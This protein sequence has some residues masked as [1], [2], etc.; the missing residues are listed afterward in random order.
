MKYKTSHALQFVCF[1]LV[2]MS[3]Q[4]WAQAN[5]S[6]SGTVSDKTGSVIPGAKVS[7]HSQG[8][9]IERTA[10]TD[11]S[12][13]YTVPLLPVA[14][15]KLEVSAAN[16]QTVQQHDIQ[17]Q[18]DEH[19]EVNFSLALASVSEKVEVEANTEEVAV[20]TTNP[21]LGQ[22]INEKQVAQLPLNGRNFVQL[23]TLTPGTTQETNP[24][25]FFNGGGSSEVSTRG[26]FSLSV[27]GSRASSTDWLFDDADNNELTAGG[28]AVIPSIDAIQEFKVLTFNYSAQYGTRAGPTVLI[29]S[30]SGSNGFHGTAFEFFRNTALDAKSYFAQTKEKFNLNQFGFSLGGPI[31]K[32]KTFFFIDY[33]ATRR[34]TGENFFGGF[35]PTAGMHT[36]DFSS[37]AAQLYN[38]YSTHLATVGGVQ[39]AVR[40][41]FMCDGAG[42]ALAV[43]SDGT[44]ASGTPCNI[45]PQALIDPVAQQMI[46]LF[47]LPNLSGNSGGNYISSPTKKLDEGSFD[48][49][50]DHN[51]T[52]S[53]RL[54]A[55]FSYDQATVFLPGGTPGFAEPDPFSSTQNITNHGRNAAISETHIFSNTSVNEAKFGYD[56]IFNHINSFGTGSCIGNTLGIPGA[57]LG[58]VSCGLTATSIGGGYWGLGDRGFAPFQGGTN[59]FDISD[60]FDMIRGKHNIRIGGEIRANQMNVLTN[61]F[62]DGFWVY[63]N[64][65]SSA[66]GT[67]PGT[68]INAAGFGGGDNMA[69]FMLGL[70]DLAL[71]DQTFK[72]ATTGRRWKLYRPYVQDDWQVNKD[73]TLNLG[74]AWAFVTPI[75]ESENRQANFDFATGTFLIP[76]VN[77]N[78]AV[79]IKMDKTAVE[80]RIG[81]AWK[82]FGSAKTAVRAGY[83]IF[84]DSS[85][86]QGGQ[87]LWENPPFFQESAFAAFF[88]DLCPTASG[89]CANSFTP[90]GKTMSQGFP[91]LS[92]PTDPAT[93]GGNLQ[94]QNLNFKI[95]R[96]QQYNVNVERELPG[97]VVLTVGYAGSRSSHVLIDGINLNVGSPAACGV[98]SGYTLGCGAGGAAFGAPYPQYGTIANNGDTG[99]AHYDS[100]QIKAETKNIKHGLYALIGYTHARALDT[101][102]A[103]GIGTS[104][105]STYYP[106]PGTSKND[107]GLSQISVNHSFTGSVIYD[108][109]FGRGRQFGAN[110]NRVEDAALGGWQLNVIERIMS[111]FPLFMTAS[112]NNSG[113]SFASNANRPNQLCTGQLSDWTVNKFFDTTCYV[114]PPQGQLGNSS[115]TPLFGP[116]FVNTDLSAVKFFHFTEQTSMEFRAE[117]FNVFN[118]A[119]FYVPVTDVDSANFGQIT[120]TVNNPRLIQFALKIHF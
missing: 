96:V 46:N 14:T 81:V 93:F 6:F 95:G 37:L 65:W 38:P 73:L 9:G 55:R 76:G 67:I 5:G 78:G 63:T 16:F 71:H 43:G 35:V 10:I 108:L 114:D 39:T 19:R 94:S 1:L 21:T 18:V 85:W 91:I 13:H 29:T 72:G 11:G 23:A 17:L 8:T 86:N 110:W 41:P 27:G 103:D 64:S 116:G 102:F 49:R 57:N 20:Q 117:F 54:F 115:R 120:E 105:G 74:L 52:N 51:L 24:H 113:V 80:P 60:S 53:D 59:V 101:G 111:G 31:R 15:Y 22:V 104:T 56:R 33:Q 44:Q 50:L 83:G 84:H 2:L 70:P 34:R 112:S 45:I 68:T 100:L 92:Q 90:T 30:K 7:I 87:G 36:G 98:V 25:S 118:H 61:A 97:A 99:K 89:A 12:G 69:D 79:G 42:N 32:D 107:W 58:G 3:A 106:L 75:T 119:Q 66:T 77:S 47:P 88:P 109:P 4:C 40:D 28:I 62:Q 48:V 82:P 26:S